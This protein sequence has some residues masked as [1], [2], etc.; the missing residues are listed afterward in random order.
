[1]RLHVVRHGESVN[2]AGLPPVPDPPLTPLGLAQA[3]WLGACW[4]G[5]AFDGL[6]C[7]PL[8]RALQT[9]EPLLAAARVGRTV[10]WPALVEWN[11]SSPPD[12]HPPAEI[13]ARFP[14]VP[15]DPPLHEVGWPEYPGSETAADVVR[16]ARAVL[17]RLVAE[18]PPDARLVVVAHNRFDGALLCAAL[19]A[20]LDRVRFDQGN[21]RVNTL[22]YADGRYTLRSVNSD[23][24]WVAGGGQEGTPRPGSAAT[25]ELRPDELDVYLL[26]GGLAA[27]AAAQG[28]LPPGAAWRDGRLDAVVAADPG[29]VGRRAAQSL[30]RAARGRFEVWPDAAEAAGF[31]AQ[32]LADALWDHAARAWPQGGAIA[33]VTP[34]P[35]A[36][37]VLAAAIG[38][39]SGARPAVVLDEGS[40]SHVRLQQGRVTVDQ[41]NSALRGVGVGS[42]SSAEG[43]LRRPGGAPA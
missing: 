38:D 32:A 35:M 8:W 39:G 23:P 42:S 30:A 18:F 41:A 11:R 4:R 17:Q 29:E 28:A 5:E 22:D 21:G 24:S 27:E 16:R 2:N 26:A 12:G 14:G 33:V 3:A 25:R 10:A 7:S 40:L 13:A 9:A 6:V 19:G 37:R 1:M 36:G 20:D 15:C 43:P 34:A 31:N